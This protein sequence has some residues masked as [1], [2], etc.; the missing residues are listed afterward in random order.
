MSKTTKAF[1]RK[2][3]RLLDHYA[4]LEMT[5]C[6]HAVDMLL[7]EQARDELIAWVTD[8]MEERGTKP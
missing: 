3:I 6:G 5:A 8:E 7:A 1:R 2:F 4:H